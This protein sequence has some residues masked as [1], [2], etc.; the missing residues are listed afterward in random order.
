MFT[1]TALVVDDSFTAQAVLKKL[2]LQFDYH[3]DTRNSGTEALNYLANTKPDVIFLDHIMPGMNGF[4][5]LRSLKSDPNLRDIPVIMY[6]SQAAKKYTREA[7]ALGATGVLS[8]QVNTEILSQMLDRAEQQ[9]AHHELIVD[10]DDDDENLSGLIDSAENAVSGINDTQ[11]RQRMQQELNQLLEQQREQMQSLHLRLGN[12]MQQQEQIHAQIHQ[13]GRQRIFSIA[14]WLITALL[15]VV[16]YLDNRDQAQQIT[17]LYDTLT[18]QQ[19][20]LSLATTQIDDNLQWVHERS[21]EEYEDL[22]FM[23][24]TLVASMEQTGRIELPSGKS[25]ANPSDENK[26]PESANR[27]A[28]LNRDRAALHQE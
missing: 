26:N 27:S 10:Y 13:S 17:Q 18:G 1:K 25:L 12:L 20:Q 16:L 19:E 2:L 23:L 21:R 9:V 14:M 28:E 4:Q 6:T 15:F 8:K 5:V 22:L 3:V 11:L 7:L 24:E